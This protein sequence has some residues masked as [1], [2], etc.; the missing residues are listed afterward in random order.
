MLIFLLW[1]NWAEDL[2]GRS[3]D[4]YEHPP[5]RFHPYHPIPQSALLF[6]NRHQHPPRELDALVALVS[7]HFKASSI[8]FLRH[9]MI[10][11]SPFFS[12]AADP[13]S[14]FPADR[15]GNDQADPSA[16]AH[17]NTPTWQ[18]ST[19]PRRPF[20]CRQRLQNVHLFLKS[21]FIGQQTAF[22]TSQ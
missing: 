16:T 22:V 12:S 11:E 21:A 15:A 1:N 20:H 18:L 8:W 19:L 4:L 5:Q 13:Y 17:T 2:Q 10:L 6:R 9:E 7:D 14:S 3:V